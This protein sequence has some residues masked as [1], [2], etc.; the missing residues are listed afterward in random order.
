[1]YRSIYA[2]SPTAAEDVVS[3]AKN[4]ALGAASDPT[5]SQDSQSNVDRSARQPAQ[6][7]APFFCTNCGKDYTGNKSEFY[8]EHMKRCKSSVSKHGNFMGKYD[9]NTGRLK[10]APSTFNAKESAFSSGP[11]H[12][13]APGIS[14]IP[15]DGGAKVTSGKWT[16]A[17]SVT[18]LGSGPI[19]SPKEI[20]PSP[21]MISSRFASMTM[22]EK[23][24]KPTGLARSRFAQPVLDALPPT[25]VVKDSEASTLSAGAEPFAPAS[26][27]LPHGEEALTAYF[28]KKFQDA[29]K[30]HAPTVTTSSPAAAPRI[31]SN[32]GVSFDDN[33][34]ALKTGPVGSPFKNG[35][36]TGMTE[37]SSKQDLSTVGI[38][39][40]ATFSVVSSKS[41]FKYFP[42]FPGDRS[43]VL[44]SD[45]HCK[46]TQD[47]AKHLAQPSTSNIIET[48][49]QESA[50]GIQ[51]IQSEIEGWEI[52]S[53]TSDSDDEL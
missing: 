24:S 4:E 33:S 23:T 48:V 3:P 13:T 22:Q 14:S 9:R 39:E 25:P 11:T 2:P 28:L 1:M 15:Q 50:G 8:A 52:K 26:P 51:L 37:N 49:D 5:A 43:P 53:I 17:R 36:S 27:P 30:T 7:P 35:R 41:T 29:L 18:S 46:D 40:P 44:A 38:S 42:E 20:Q 10:D 19:E 34:T 32:P 21:G 47:S 31:T 16:N 45:S 12:S 6:Q